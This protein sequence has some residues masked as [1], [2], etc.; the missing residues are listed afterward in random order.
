MKHIVVEIG[1]RNASNKLL[2]RRIS[3]LCSIYSFW[4]KSKKVLFEM[5][6]SLDGIL[7]SAV[8][9]WNPH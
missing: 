6:T 7:E 2:C 8:Y 4:M 1:L 9:S 5:D 3:F